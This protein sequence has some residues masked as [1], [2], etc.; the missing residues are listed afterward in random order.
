[1][2]RTKLPVWHV[3]AYWFGVKSASPGTFS[4]RHNSCKTSKNN[5]NNKSGLLP[6]GAQTALRLAWHG[7]CTFLGVGFN[8]WETV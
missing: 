2:R 5:K 8:H 4:R 3:F 6:E 7:P 1:M